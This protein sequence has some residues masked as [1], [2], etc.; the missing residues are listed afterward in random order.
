MTKPTKT[1]IQALIA[2]AFATSAPAWAQADAS[3]EALLKRLDALTREM[4]ALKAQ[5]KANEEKASRP[6]ATPVDK[7]AEQGLSKQAKDEME[8]AAGTSEGIE[9]VKTPKASLKFYGMVDV[10]AELLNGELAKGG[11]VD[12]SLRVSNGLI[13]PHFG[14]LGN[15]QLTEGLQGSF[16]LEGSLAPDSGTS[17]IGGRLF[18]RQAWVGLSG[19]FGTVRLGRQYT[20]VRM[21]WDDANPYGTGNQGLRLLDPR[22]SNPRA[23][24]SI[25]YVLTFG[26]FTAGVNYSGGWDAVNGNSSN[27]G[28][29][30]NG[31][32]NCAGEVPDQTQQCKEV[33]F[34][35]KYA[36][37]P[38]GV[39]AAY[40]KLNGGTSATYG[41]LTSPTLSDTRKVISAYYRGKGGL[42]VTGGWIARNNEG[43][44]AT[45][46]SDMYWVEGIFPV[47][48]HVFLDGLLAHLK[49][50]DS[51]NKA[52][53]INLRGRYVLNK[54][55][56]IYMTLANMDNNGTLALPATASTPVPTPK[57]GEKQYSLITGVL[58]KF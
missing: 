17:G 50:D 36:G 7:S 4:E 26:G 20:A 25:S 13:T 2:A 5:V 49:Y 22:I 31:G 24:N 6:L 45:P 28:P 18:G 37:G 39:A 58:Y 40:E 34:G 55:T 27:T 54:D 56:T 29:A 44:A 10:G 51:A 41:G 1:L 52:T 11:Q 48:Q 30:N 33:S 23:D 15:G 16:N 32:A 38:W 19:A 42:K 9:L 47:S 57:A 53:L 12:S 35:M 3:N 21:G 14:V 46:K 8:D 43:N